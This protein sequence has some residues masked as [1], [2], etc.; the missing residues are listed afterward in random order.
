MYT[1]SSLGP[2]N[3]GSFVNQ[4]VGLKLKPCILRGLLGHWGEGRLGGVNSE[5]GCPVRGMYVVLLV[6]KREASGRTQRNPSYEKNMVLLNR[7]KSLLILGVPGVCGCP[8]C[9]LSEVVC[10]HIKHGGYAIDRSIPFVVSGVVS[11]CMVWT[12]TRLLT[13]S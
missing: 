11:H 9:G 12:R 1:W 10:G 8:Q 2:S 5:W 6:W 7:G 3:V 13:G 4:L